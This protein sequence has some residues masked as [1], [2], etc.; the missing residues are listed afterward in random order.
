MFYDSHHGR[1]VEVYNP[2]LS[3]PF[4]QCKHEYLISYNFSLYSIQFYLSKFFFMGIA[5]MKNNLAAWLS[6]QADHHLYYFQIESPSTALSLSISLPLSFPFADPQAH[7]LLPGVQSF[8]PQQVLTGFTF[9]SCVLT[10]SF[11]VRSS[12]TMRCKK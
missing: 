2:R 9:E 8:C 11:L 12:S 6:Y 5:T 4:G 10:L 3:F 7:F 1:S